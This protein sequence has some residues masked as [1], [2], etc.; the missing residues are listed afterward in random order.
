M[1]H[2]MSE[3]HSRYQTM[4]V[5]GLVV[6]LIAAVLFLSA[7]LGLSTTDTADFFLRDVSDQKFGWKYELLSDGTVTEGTPEFGEYQEIS[8][9]LDSIQAVSISRTMTE[10][11]SDDAE[12]EFTCHGDKMVEVFLDDLLLFSALPDGQRNKEGFLLLGEADS[13]LSER[14]TLKNEYY[15][16]G[17]SVRLSLPEGCQG[18]TL[19][20]I[21]YFFD[22]T[23]NC[24][25]VYPALGTYESR[26]AVYVAETVVPVALLILCAVLSILLLAVFVL[27][28]PNGRNDP[29]TLLLVL[30]FTLLFVSTLNGPTISVAGDVAD[31]PVIQILGEFYLLPLFLYLALLLPGWKRNLLFGGTAAWTVYIIVQLRMCVGAGYYVADTM[32][33]G[34]FLLSLLFFAVFLFDFITRG[35][36]LLDRK[37][38]LLYATLTAAVFFLCILSNAIRVW[39]GDI[40]TCLETMFSLA[41]D[42]YFIVLM[43]YVQNTCAAMAVI[44][45]VLEFLRRNT[46]AHTMVTVLEERGRATRKEYNRILDA[47]RATNSLRHELSHHL[48]A[49]MGFLRDGE[50]ERACEYITSV[51]KDLNDLPVLRYSK[52]TIVNV[53][54]GSYLDRAAKMGISVK[55]SLQVPNELPIQ[56]ED[57]SVFLSNLLQNALEACERMDAGSERYIR[58]NMSVY[59]TY[60]AIGCTNS[61]SPEKEKA[62]DAAQQ[63]RPRHSHGY[64]LKAMSNIAE[65]Y[66]SILNIEKTAS[67]FSVKTLLHMDKPLVSAEPGEL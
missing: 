40:L 28:L 52:N 13:H 20:L 59:R 67:E 33:Q 15:P 53:I 66:G 5:V 19:R 50:N 24:E 37:R 31:Q 2:S 51:V 23:A 57:L 18:R 60:L 62:S 3:K 30:Y 46:E 29:R 6:I 21:T 44:I 12:I 32:G 9:P 14:L 65:K 48:T 4:S 45:L 61:M 64:G 26:Y 1:S 43:S 27:D 22:G 47:E 25:P 34:I 63:R 35:R 39:D 11:L 58:I 7:L 16:Y 17:N 38:L 55:Y 41:F 42:G 36:R 49:L 54:A 56:D 8:F 10:E